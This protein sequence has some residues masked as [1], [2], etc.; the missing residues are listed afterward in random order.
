METIDED[1]TN[2]IE[3]EHNLFEEIIHSI[4]DLDNQ[5][6]SLLVQR[7][8]NH[9]LFKNMCYKYNKPKSDNNL[10]KTTF[11]RI[12]NNYSNNKH[13]L[14]NIFNIIYKYN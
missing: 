9:T 13:Y 7:Q 11:S 5:I 8:I 10:I 2:F 4:N 12:N 6:L 14:K 3:L 1:E